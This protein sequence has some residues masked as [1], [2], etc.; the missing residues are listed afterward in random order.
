M[1]DIII[2]VE[3]LG[4]KYR[5]QHSPSRS[6]QRAGGQAERQRCTALR[7]VLLPGLEMLLWRRLQP[8]QFLA[9]ARL[10]MTDLSLPHE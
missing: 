8:G 6:A 3:N 1:S 4:K 2:S 10:G 9:V 5:I 7:D